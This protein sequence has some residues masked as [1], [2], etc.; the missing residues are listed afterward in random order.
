M[1]SP[2][3]HAEPPWMTRS[4][5]PPA[6]RPPLSLLPN[7]EPPARAIQSVRLAIR[8]QDNS[9]VM[10]TNRLSMPGA[11]PVAAIALISAMYY[12]T[13]DQTGLDAQHPATSVTSPPSRAAAIY[14]GGRGGLGMAMLCRAMLRSALLNGFT[15]GTER[16][17]KIGGEAM[18]I[19]DFFLVGLVAGTLAD[20][21]RRQRTRS[22]VTAQL[23]AVTRNFRQTLRRNEAFPTASAI[24]QL[25]AGLGPRVRTPWRAS[26]GQAAFLGRTPSQRSG[27]GVLEITRRRLR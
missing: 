8:H 13:Q 26:V 18:E 7:G 20:R 24:G 9:G 16:G 21:E 15:E 5:L 25:S 23:D 11:V 19:L 14:L 22:S 27:G 1:A 12:A 2:V 10:R 17:A 4:G 3:A 6:W